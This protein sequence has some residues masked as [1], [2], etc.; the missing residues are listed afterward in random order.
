MAVKQIL[1]ATFSGDRKTL[2]EVVGA[3]NSA[4]MPAEVTHDGETGS[5]RLH[6]V[7]EDGTHLVSKDG[8]VFESEPCV[9]V[10]T[11]DLAGAQEIAGKCGWR[12]RM[13]GDSGFRSL[14]E[15]DAVAAGLHLPNPGAVLLENLRRA[16][17]DPVLLAAVREV[18]G[19]K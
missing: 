3:F 19:V 4:G 11:A 13:H 8:P 5:A 16:A 7:D 17:E 9:D 10:L 2:G 1:L 6:A 14:D 15:A 18:L 12:L